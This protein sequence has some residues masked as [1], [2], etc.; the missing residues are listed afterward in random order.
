MN[1][2]ERFLRYVKVHTTSDP[3]SEAAPSSAI[4]LDLARILVEEMTALGLENAHVDEFGV[5]YGWLPATPGREDQPALGFIAH[6]DTSPDYSGENVK[7]QIIEQY[8]GGDVVL[9]GTGDV[10]S[11]ANFPTLTGLKGMTLITSD[12]TTLLG[13]DDKAG[14]AEILTA[15][16][17]I[18]AENKPHG[19]LCIAFTPDEEIGMGVAHFDIEKFGAPLAYTVDGGREGELAFETFNAASAKVEF[20]GMSVHPGSSKDTMIN[21]ALVAMEFNALLPAC[22][23]PR[24]TE[25]YEGFFHL[26]DMQG[27]VS[28]AVLEYIVRDHDRAA[29]EV[30]KQTLRHAA[31]VINERYGREVVSLTLTDTYYNMADKIAPHMELIENARK[32][33]LLAGMEPFVEPVRGGTDGCRLS[34]MGMPTP[35]L[36]TGGFAY[37]GK[38]EHIAAESLERCAKMVELL[39]TE[40]R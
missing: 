40:I 18:I 20:T 6:M 22:D 39:M 5:V 1:A 32:A 38:F 31:K 15:V 3:A 17:R 37:H 36:C 34:E 11:V 23:T 12:G 33:A 9:P 19:R 30:R 14:I 13:A 7:P 27:D 8:D 35:N 29:F 28:H 10:L 4:Q 21:A 26:H 16:E 2:C 25:G 24:L